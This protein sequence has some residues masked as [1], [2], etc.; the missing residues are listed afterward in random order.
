MEA[1]VL[2]LILALP[3]ALIGFLV[4]LKRELTRLNRRVGQ[5]E[6][7]W[8]GVER[9]A[10]PALAAPS[11]RAPVP[12]P[13]SP[14]LE[15]AAEPGVAALPPVIPVLEAAATPAPAAAVAP[16]PGVV[17]P[18][19]ATGSLPAVPPLLPSRNWERFLGVKL[20]AWIGGLALFLGVAFFVKYSFERNLITPQMR[21]ALGAAT[22]LALVGGGL[23]LARKR[24][25]VTAQTLCATGTVILYAIIF[26]AHAY[27][28]FIGVAPAFALMALVTAGAFALAVNLGAPVIAILGLLGG[29]LTPPLLSTG[30]DN[31]LGLFGYVGLL[32]VG[33]VAVAL[34]RR[35]S[36]QVLLAAVATALMQAAWVTKFHTPEK[37]WVALAI[38][39]G[40]SLLFLL[41]LLAAHKWRVADRWGVAATLVASGAAL[42][43]AFHLAAHDAGLTAARTVPFFVFLL[44]V[45]LGLLLVSWTQRELR[46]AHLAAGLA[47]FAILLA[48]TFR[49]LAPELLAPA[50]CAYFLFAVLHAVAPLVLERLRPSNV[51][52]GLANLFP[53]AALLLV[54]APLY[55]MAGTAGWSWSVV[56]LIDATAIGV[57]IATASLAAVLAACLLTALAG[58]LWIFQLPPE[59]AMVPGML[60]VVGAFGAFFT[61]AGV[62]AARAMS[63]KGAET[64]PDSAMVKPELAVPMTALST[65][66]PFL[67]L[68]LVVVQTDVPNPTP[69]FVVGAFI[70]VLLLAVVRLFEV[71]V[72]ALLG[73][74]AVLCLEHVW[75]FH[76]RGQGFDTVSLGWFLGF[77]GVFLV[78]PFLVQARLAGR[79]LPWIAAVLALPLHFY[80]VYQTSLRVWPDLAAKGL[81]PA[82]LAIPCLAGLA[83]LAQS[84]PP[85]DGQRPTLLALFGGATLFFVTLIFPIQFE[86]QWLT[87]SWALEGLALLWLFHR[88]PHPGLPLVGVA[89][90]VTSCVR[91]ALN[92]FVLTAY[93]R[94]GTPLLNWYLYTYGIVSACLLAGGWLLAP[95]RHR[96]RDLSVPPL[97]Y[98]MGGV[99]AFLLVNIEIADY[100]TGPGNRLIFEFNASL[101]QDMTYSLA[102]GLFAFGLLSLGFKARSAPT[103]YAGMGLLVVTLLKLFLHDLWRLGGL[104][105]IGSLVGLAVLLILVSFIYQR[106]LSADAL[107]ERRAAAGEGASAAGGGTAPPGPPPG[108]GG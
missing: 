79:T 39:Y 42:V 68:A 104:Y 4:H 16:R 30:V 3:A 75:F 103:R 61:G 34:R 62:I 80:L 91:L 82:M 107:R 58:A 49:H 26:A 7:R 33:L 98:S 10:E 83:R 24:Q 48:W 53:A 19:A 64:A 76:R 12:P 65:L 2:L 99:L 95:P 14:A 84:V 105:R 38:F 1:F 90:L 102:W 43:F 81:V 108:P 25:D 87:V 29:F 8:A 77:A 55:R 28:N 60:G 71:D 36:Y 59:P 73:L 56:L 63:L 35:W 54:L 92:P 57:A 100:F 66:M 6:S 93:G 18:A 47:G 67:L 97:L 37:F 22:G 27:Y 85:E 11:A 78:F 89:L 17:A 101:G 40:F 86:R 41:A 31:P 46:A 74:G 9:R 20:F 96:I 69:V 13:I 44:L 88:V 51:P 50:L 23:W 94:T 21:V 32:D 70:V 106:F 72:L 5:L 15:P 52:P 45:D